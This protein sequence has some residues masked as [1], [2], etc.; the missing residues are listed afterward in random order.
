MSGFP[1]INQKDPCVEKRPYGTE[2]KI[3]AVGG[4]G[5][6]EGQRLR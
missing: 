5:T 1:A 3:G 6:L 4:V 2:A